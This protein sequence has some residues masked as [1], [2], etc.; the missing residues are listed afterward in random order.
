MRGAAASRWRWSN[1]A[2][3]GRFDT[4]DIVGGDRRARR[5]RRGLAGDVHHR[6][7]AG[8]PARHRRGRAP[9]RRAPVARRLPRAGRIPCRRHGARCR[10]RRRRQLQVPARRTRARAT[11]TCTRAT[12]M[13]RCARSIR[14]GSPSAIRLPIVRPDPPQYG[15]GRRRVP[16]I[17]AAGTAVL[18]GARRADLHAGYRCRPSPR[19]FARPAAAPGRPAARARLLRDG[20]HRGSRRLRRRR[21]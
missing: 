11:C 13:A 20:R 15:D 17:D 21:R 14:A 7:A 9:R 10:F 5:P 6:A 3:D 4:A 2:P 12:S 1:R 19:A 16:G 8:R 18:P